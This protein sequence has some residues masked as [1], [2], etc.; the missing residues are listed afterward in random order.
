MSDRAATSPMVR[1]SAAIAGVGAGIVDL[2]RSAHGRHGHHL[3]PLGVHYLGGAISGS[4]PFLLLSGLA[5]VL[6]ARSLLR[7]ERSAWWIAS[8]AAAVSVPVHL[9]QGADGVGLLASISLLAILV[10]GRHQFVARHDPAHARQ[11]FFVLVAGEITVL[12]YGVFGLYLLGVHFDRPIGWTDA[13]WDSGRLLFLLPATQ[14][15]PITDHGVWLLDSIRF[16]SLSVVLVAAARLIATCAQR[17]G[18]RGDEIEHARRLVEDRATST[19]APFAL[20][21][22]KFWWFS[23]DGEAVIAY[24]L[25]GRTAVALGDPIGAP[26]SRTDVLRS[27]VEMCERNAWTPALH[28]L[29]PA[30]VTEAHA[31]GLLTVKIGE[32]AFIEFENWNLEDRSNKSLRS[33]LRRVERTGARVVELERPIDAPTMDRLRSVSDAW[34]RTGGHRERT[35]SVGRFDEAYL[36]ATTVLAVM[37]ADDEILAFVNVLPSY[38]SEY[39]NFDL[40]RRIP[41]APNGVIET[42]FVALLKRFQSE[43]LRGMT[44]GLAPLANL[45]PTTLTGRALRAVYERGSTVFNFAG[46]RSFKDRWNPRWEPRYV[47]TRR[48]SDLPKVALAVSRAGELPDPRSFASRARSLLAAYPFSFGLIGVVGYLMAVG[49]VDHRVWRRLTVSLQLGWT[50]LT[51]L[52]WWRIATAPLIQT[53]PG[54]QLWNLLFLIVAVPLAEKRFGTRRA[55]LLFAL[56]DWVMT[57]PVLVVLRTAGALGVHAAL[58]DALHRDGGS[59]AGAWGLVAALAIT[60][61]DRTLRRAVLIGTIGFHVAAFGLEHRLVDIQH[62]I[63]MGVGAG[64]A[65]TARRRDAPEPGPTVERRPG[66]MVG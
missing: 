47:A 55:A 26:G 41:T 65:A 16:A 60:I 42:L 50:D 25:V 11:G 13:L 9:V 57:I 21:D 33:A 53:K 52:Q 7:A 32:E 36:R 61:P 14:S 45:D 54:L 24:R 64:L 10:V 6:S 62:L 18:R 46:L 58:V 2:A 43:G 29:S 22:D 15:R 51:R 20:L 39:G 38:H 28:Q 27:F 3:G 30:G 48:E 44:L 35:F 66:A 49:G 31:A 40:M 19:L 5:L 12:L 63:A 4:R 56:S 34:L 37:S 23:D 59:S 17:E 1:R 8:I